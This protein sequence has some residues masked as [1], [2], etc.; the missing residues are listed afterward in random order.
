MIDDTFIHCVNVSGSKLIIS[1]ADLSQDVCVDL[2][3]F[4]LNLDSFEGAE[5]DPVELISSETLQQFSPS[6]LAAA[7]R[8]PKD[9]SLM[10]YTSGT[11]G[12]PKACAIRNMLTLITSTPLSA[13]ANNPSKYHPFRVYSPLPLFHGTAFFTGLCTALGNG[14]TLCLG[15]RFSASRFWK[16][17]H[18][19][20]ATRILYIGELCRY[21]L[22]TPPSPYDQDHKC[23]VASGNGL[24][25]EIWEKFRKRFNVPEIREFYRSTEG[26]AKFD[27]HGVGAWGAGKVGFSGPIRRFLEDDTFVVKYDTDTEMPYRDP[28]TGF[29]VRAALGQEG[30]VIGRVRDRGMMIEYLGN[31]GATEEKLLRDVFRKGDLFQRTGDLVV[32]E[33]SGWV[34]FQ[35]RVGD[36][37]RWKGENVSAGEIRDHICRIEGVHD[38]VVYGVKLSGYVFGPSCSFVL[39][40][41]HY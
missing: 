35:D 25:G 40:R 11:T 26:V 19:S 31:E 13:D 4:T 24:R 12:K 3:H 22:A 34:K 9:P 1:S 7:K 41:S 37:F 36:T 28:V 20:G 30:E 6:G 18:D 15:R 2:P 10:I 8:S 38:A 33:K 29:C 14:G 23:I 27:N 32:Q 17:V 39:V 21:L 16:E 5:T